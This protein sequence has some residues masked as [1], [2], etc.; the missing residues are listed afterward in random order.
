[1][2]GIFGSVVYLVLLTLL[3]ELLGV[4][5]VVATMISFTPVF[6]VSYY[7]T[8]TWVFRSA[9]KHKSALIKY[10]VVT[11]LGFL[12]NV[13]GMYLAV[14]IMDMWYL[15]SQVILFIIVAMNNYLLNRYWTF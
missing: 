12:I 15:S 10:A 5:P 9:T 3:V 2:V 8:H 6:F 1:M 14:H 11:G 13:T 7:L 4:E